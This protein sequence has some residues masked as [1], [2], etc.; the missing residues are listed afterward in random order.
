M[1]TGNSAKS[2]LGSGFKFPLADFRFVIPSEARNLA[3]LRVQSEIPR[4]AR[5]D[6]HFMTEMRNWRLRRRVSDF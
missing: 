6:K 5:N 2:R 4:F 1:E 3:L